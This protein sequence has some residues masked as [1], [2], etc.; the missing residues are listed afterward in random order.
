VKHDEGVLYTNPKL[1][2]FLLGC[3]V[4]SKKLRVRGV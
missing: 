2:T 4:T 3:R 1:T